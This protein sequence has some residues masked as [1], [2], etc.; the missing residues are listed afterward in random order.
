MS[1]AMRRV[2]RYGS[3][4]MVINFS[5][6]GGTC[7]GGGGVVGGI[8]CGTCLLPSIFADTEKKQEC[9]T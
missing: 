5:R 9:I 6:V 1:H 2:V 3:A 4:N 8:T 7:G